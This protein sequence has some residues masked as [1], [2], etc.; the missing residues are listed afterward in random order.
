MPYLTFTTVDTG[1]SGKVLA[2]RSWGR[3]FEIQ[4]RSWKL[5]LEK[6]SGFCL[7]WDFS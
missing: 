5:R 2:T 6:N 7:H 3:R 4:T 1:K